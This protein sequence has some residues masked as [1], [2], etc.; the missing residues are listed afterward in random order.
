MT[1][2]TKQIGGQ[3]SS[4]NS[5]DASLY[6]VCHPCAF[7]HH[8][9]TVDWLGNCN[10]DTHENEWRGKT[11]DNRYRRVHY[12][13][14]VWRRLFA[15]SDIYYCLYHFAIRS[16]R[17]GYSGKSFADDKVKFG[18]ISERGKVNE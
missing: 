16:L 7:G 11:L 14:A 2:F 12:W 8:Y 1:T 10:G 13:N 18:K 3:H 9:G 15:D 17:G 6:R 4:K 5:L